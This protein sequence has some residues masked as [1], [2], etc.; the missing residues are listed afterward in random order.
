MDTYELPGRPGSTEQRFD[1]VNTNRGGRASLGNSKHIA[2]DNSRHSHHGNIHLGNVI[3]HLDPRTLPRN[4][5]QWRELLRSKRCYI[6]LLLFIIALV[7]VIICIPT[8]IVPQ[9]RP[10]SNRSVHDLPSVDPTNLTPLQASKQGHQHR[11][12]HYPPRQKPHTSYQTPQRILLS[13]PRPHQPRLRLRTA[14]S[15]RLPFSQTHV[16]KETQRSPLHPP[17]PMSQQ[18]RSQ[19]MTQERLLFRHSLANGDAQVDRAY[20][21]RIVARRHWA[22]PRSWSSGAISGKESVLI[23][24]FSVVISLSRQF[25]SMGMMETEGVTLWICDLQKRFWF[26]CV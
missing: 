21:T 12:I 19:A 7:V 25:C 17:L 3:V 24:R 4:Q 9:P 13:F 23:P 6:P 11:Q 1:G 20:L 15:L 2:T 10:A 14:V 5:R 26:N 18:S 16:P 8:V 22:P